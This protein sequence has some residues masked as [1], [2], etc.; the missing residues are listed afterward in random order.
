MSPSAISI[1]PGVRVSLACIQCRGRHV[2]CDAA[3]PSCS[4]CRS[5]GTACFYQKSRRG[6]LDRATLSWRRA[7]A[8]RLQGSS[9]PDPETLVVDAPTEST[10]LLTD[11][12]LTSDSPP[13]L[14][15]ASEAIS[16][17]LLQLYYASFHPAHPFVLPFHHFKQKLSTG[18][19]RRLAAVMQYIGSLYA[20]TVPS[21]PLKKQA[22]QALKEIPPQ[23]SGYDV[24][25]LMLFG[26]A[27]YWTDEQDDGL[28]VFD[29]AISKALDMGMNRR[30]YALLYGGGENILE[31]SWRRT[32]WSLYHTDFNF[33]ALKH[34]EPF[35]TSNIIT[36]VDLPCEEHEYESGVSFHSTHSSSAFLTSFFRST[37]IHV[38]CSNTRIASFLIMT[39]FSLLL[40]I[41]SDYHVA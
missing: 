9:A 2:R 15:E 30:E 36:D 6:G 26:I 14:P 25:A 34:M 19:L 4:R 16:E 38:L 41:S 5:H 18:L 20:S 24:Q 3:K 31:E 11:G 8:Q 40:P 12:V 33:A 23:S 39:W 7:Q 29:E 13:L 1:K 37:P 22:R 17:Q 27:L 35:R 10:I 21:E 28:R 32:W